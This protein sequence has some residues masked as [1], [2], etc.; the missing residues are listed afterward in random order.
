M[1][2][3]RKVA[4]TFFL[5]MLLWSG[6]IA[7]RVEGDP[8]GGASQSTGQSAEPQPVRIIGP[9]IARED[10]NE[11]T[12]VVL[13]NGLTV[14]VY[15]RKDLPLVCVGTYVKVG[16]LAEP[17]DLVGITHLLERLMF[18]ETEKRG[19]G[20]IAKETRALGGVLRSRTDPDSTFHYLLVPAGEFR[21]A[22]DLQSDALRNPRLSE[23]AVNREI[24]RIV[25]EDRRV[26]DLPEAYSLENLF[27]LTF[28]GS[29][30]GRRWRGSEAT[31]QAITLEQLADY[32]KRWYRPG[33]VIVTVSGDLDRRSVLEEVVKRY[34]DIPASEPVSWKP[35]ALA[36]PPQMRYRE[37]RGDLNHVI[38]QI[39]MPAP[40]VFSKDWYAFRVLDAMLTKGRASLLQSKLR[41][42]KG[43]LSSLNSTLHSLKG[44]GYWVLSLSCDFAKLNEAELGVFGELERI[45]R[46]EFSDQ[47][48]LR[49][50]KLLERDYYADQ[51]S[52]ST[53]AFQL[54]RYDDLTKFSEWKN[55][56]ERIRAV[57]REQVVDV[58]RQYYL[59]AH[60]SVLEYLP[61]KAPQRI[62]SPSEY[63]R[64][65]EL[66]LPKTLEEGRVSKE[67]K[68]PKEEDKTPRSGSTQL[69]SEL[70]MGAVKFPLKKYSI[71]R[72]P[73]VLVQESHALPLTS[74][75]VLFPG[76]R[77]FETEKNQ[78]ITE[79]MARSCL[80]G[81][82][83]GS[84]G[85]LFAQMEELG[86]YAQVQ[87]E[88]DFVAFVLSGLAESFDKAIPIF[89]ELINSPR[90]EAD[91][92][93]KQKEFLLA[94]SAEFADHGLLLAQQLLRAAAFGH[95]P[96]GLPSHGTKESLAGLTSEEVMSW[97]ERF[98]KSNIPVVVV[99]GDT[100]GSGVVPYVAKDFSSSRREMVDFGQATTLPKPTELR[101]KQAIRERNETSLA[102]GFWGPSATD[103][104]SDV[105]TVIANLMS[106]RGGMLDRA[107]RQREGIAFEPMARFD[108]RILGGLF[109]V[110]L[111]ARPEE[112]RSLIDE[113][114]EQFAQLR[115]AFVPKELLDEAV[116]LSGG[117]ER[118]RRQRRSQQAVEFGRRLLLG[119]PVEEIED[120]ARRFSGVDQER[121]RD[122]ARQFFDPSKMATGR[123]S[124]R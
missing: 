73:D 91:E 52:L 69:S 111:E 60:C 29:P 3:L 9:F 23:D 123:V 48:L 26:E 38:V 55:A 74:L 30:L 47:D 102:I 104:G 14:I 15:E 106:G 98:V 18:T 118:I 86:V 79:L 107:F 92:I 32:R 45:K 20:Q 10:L 19:A 122:A 97:H 124:P 33:N 61:R 57:T 51:E 95:H 116:K 115:G 81:S 120:W 22:L 75:A 114:K 110:N 71:L 103:D 80:S 76:G 13:K 100:E 77:P 28:E 49:A 66:E 34:G 12:K 8:L 64:F 70:S 83:M 17:D 46:E 89:F 5:L 21:A 54:A 59:P 113:L 25:A 39:G 35:T 2:T 27:R 93:E 96:Y 36:D 31:L 41:E 1:Q 63:Q 72:G 68:A 87:V 42:T 7:Q 67:P 90:F 44:E 16:Y 58:V 121:L 24:P 85:E 50:R 99:S 78:G 101:S 84:S 94:E 65:L 4:H 117:L 119:Y 112:E 105:L 56:V 40:A 88:P 109:E 43:S 108:A 37:M 82:R 62:V 6:A 53:L 11:Y